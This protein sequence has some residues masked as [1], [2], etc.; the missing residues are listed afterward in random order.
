M[1]LEIAVVGVGLTGKQTFELTSSRL[2]A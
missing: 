2:G 1:D